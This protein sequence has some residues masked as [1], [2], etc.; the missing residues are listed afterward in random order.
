[1]VES[2]GFINDMDIKKLPVIKDFVKVFCSD[3]SR[4]DGEAI[5]DLYNWIYNLIMLNLYDYSIRMTTEVGNT[6]YLITEDLKTD[7]TLLIK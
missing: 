3:L 1:M 5:V 7:Y 4:L 6:E 2:R